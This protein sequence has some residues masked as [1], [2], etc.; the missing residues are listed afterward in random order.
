M[1]LNDEQKEMFWS[2][3]K[4]E[5]ERL[6]NLYETRLHYLNTMNQHLELVRYVMNEPITNIEKLYLMTTYK[7]HFQDKIQSLK[8][9]MENIINRKEEFM[10]SYLG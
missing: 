4:K 6:L 10:L 7:K 1:E 3:M 5:H 8:D 2:D 9:D